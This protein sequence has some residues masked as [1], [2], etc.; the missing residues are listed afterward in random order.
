MIFT[1]HRYTTYTSLKTARTALPLTAMGIIGVIFS[2]LL[3]IPLLAVLCACLATLPLPV[4]LPPSNRIKIIGSKVDL[5]SQP[6]Y[7]NLF[8][9]WTI[10]FVIG[11]L[12]VITEITI[13]TPHE[14]RL[15]PVAAL[16]LFMSMFSGYFAYQ[17]RGAISIDSSSITLNDATV[18]P[19]S[20]TNFVLEARDGEIPQIAINRVHADGSLSRAR[21]IPPGGLSVDL[22]TLLSTIVGVQE[23]GSSGAAVTPRQIVA[24]LNVKPHQDVRVGESVEVSI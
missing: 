7:K 17:R 22:N 16:A 23:L 2:L 8:A 10:A 1:W 18:F 11:G 24:M 20:S 9:T 14:W 21:S 12:S 13:K 4:A 5:G 6:V 15:I 3:K 19:M